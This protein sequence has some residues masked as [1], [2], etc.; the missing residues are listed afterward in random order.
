MIPHVIDLFAESSDSPR[1]NRLRLPQKKLPSGVGSPFAN[2]QELSVD[3]TL[4]TW[5]EV[6][7]DTYN[8]SGMCIS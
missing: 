8:A 7:N 4:M 5:N 6:C 1:G 2:V 3:G